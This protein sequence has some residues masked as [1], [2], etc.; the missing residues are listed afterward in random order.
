MSQNLVI[1]VFDRVLRKDSNEMYA[2]AA[3]LK[4]KINKMNVQC[5]FLRGVIEENVFVEQTNRVC[6]CLGVD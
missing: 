6:G 5:T 4:F 2:P 3:R 1:M